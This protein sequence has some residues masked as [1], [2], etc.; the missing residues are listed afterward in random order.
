MNLAV[1]LQQPS[2]GQKALECS[3]GDVISSPMLYTS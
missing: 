2:L 1:F 3:L